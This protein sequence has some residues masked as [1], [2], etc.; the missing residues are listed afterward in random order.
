MTKNKIEDVRDHLVQVM[1]A[2]NDESADPEALARTIERAKAMS[3]VA[4][5]YINAVKV[6]IDAVRL[7]DEVGML[8]ASMAP[9]LK[10]DRNRPSLSLR[11][12][13]QHG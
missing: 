8:P 1:E 6:E 2:L 5:S 9:P 12:E 3:S 11:G 4:T 10:C 7:V 13:N